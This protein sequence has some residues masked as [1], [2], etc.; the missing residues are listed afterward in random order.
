VERCTF[1]KERNT[2]PDQLAGE[3]YLKTFSFKGDFFHYANFAD[4]YPSF[5]HFAGE[6]TARRLRRS[7]TSDNTNYA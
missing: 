1:K 6:L 4:Q 5:A 2:S 7:G 3:F